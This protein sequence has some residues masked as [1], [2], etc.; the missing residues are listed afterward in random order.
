MTGRP[1]SPGDD[2][3][4]GHHPVGAETTG[5][6]PVGAQTTGGELVGGEQAIAGVPVGSE[7]TGGE[8][9]VLTV[10]DGEVATVVINR[11]SRRNALTWEVTRQ[12]R[13]A[14][15]V[16]RDDPV[17]RVIV[18]T[19]AGEQAFCAG[20]DLDGMAAGAGAL[21]LH[22]GRGEMAA[23][24]QDMWALGKPVIARVRGYALAGGFGLALA[25][26]LVVAAEDAVFGTPEI[27]V[28]LWPYMITVPL[29]RSLPPKRALELMMTGRRVGA[30][31]A[32]R[33]GLVTRVVAA[34]ELD[35]AVGELALALA[36]QSPAV[37]RLGRTA[38]YRVVDQAADQALPYLHAQ[39]S[40]TA[41]TEDAI[42]GLAAF[43]ERRRPVWTGR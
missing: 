39:L 15:G 13:H 10:V 2:Q 28:G 41:G 40:I 27:T 7:Q 38:F 4:R 24:F 19:G 31:E 9:E 34:S 8:R 20:A 21:E 5:G 30:A 26:D 43:A 17:V 1:C 37:M 25:C 29:L 32:E 33:L 11:P 23:L 16:L 6:E 36:A 12:L 18:L 22:H 35:D 42:E 14:F 3:P